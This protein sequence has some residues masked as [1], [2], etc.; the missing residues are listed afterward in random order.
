L[1]ELAP[2][3]RLAGDG[4]EGDVRERLSVGGGEV[5]GDAPGAW[6]RRRVGEGGED[7][8]EGRWR[9]R[10]LRRGER[11]RGEGRVEGQGRG[12]RRD[13]APGTIARGKIGGSAAPLPRKVPGMA[14]PYLDG[15]TTEKEKDI[16][17]IVGMAHLHGSATVHAGDD[18]LGIEGGAQASVT[19]PFV[20][21]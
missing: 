1:E 16:N 20:G 15:K 7:G 14:Q 12:W 4:A 6:S 13:A 10:S 3:R 5:A 8:A 2:A 21:V 9:E 18:G 17:L 19:L 11:V